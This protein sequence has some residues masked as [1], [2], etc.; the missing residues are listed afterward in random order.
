MLIWFFVVLLGLCGLGLVLCAIL[1]TLFFSAPPDVCHV[2]PLDGDASIVEGR[3]R[4]ALY[5]LKGRLYFVD[6]GLDAE[7]QMSVE[8]LLRDRHCAMLIAPDQLPQEMRWENNL[9]T[10][11]DQGNSHHGDFPE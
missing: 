4:K 8:L 2:I 6:L 1:E 5:S 10:G 11:T 3:V 9:G 7:A